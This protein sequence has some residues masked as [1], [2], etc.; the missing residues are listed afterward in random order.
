M[1]LKVPVTAT[2][3]PSGVATWNRKV[4]D[5]INQLAGSGGGFGGS[6]GSIGVLPLVDGSVPPVFIVNPDGSLIYTEI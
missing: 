2:Q 3:T 6:A 5:A 1:S 4:A